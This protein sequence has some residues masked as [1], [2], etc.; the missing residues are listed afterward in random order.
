MSLWDSEN[1]QPPASFIRTLGLPACFVIILNYLFKKWS[2]F[3][4]GLETNRFFLFLLFKN[5]CF[6]GRLGGINNWHNSTLRC[7]SSG[8]GYIPKN[9]F[10]AGNELDI[11]VLLLFRCQPSWLPSV[12]KLAWVS[13]CV[14]VCLCVC[15]AGCFLSAGVLDHPSPPT[16]IFV[17]TSFH[18]W[19][20]TW[21]LCWETLL[22]SSFPV[23]KVSLVFHGFLPAY[24]S[25][26]EL[27]KCKNNF[28][29]CPAHH[30][31]W[32]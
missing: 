1:P 19:Q 14:C 30:S 26:E 5:N 11:H 18:S 16:V 15:K 13:E 9:S 24:T 6:Y 3:F 8:L 12:P 28:S 2:F 10:L 17:L 27:T 22:G 31:A 4:P 21:H 7:V 20:W 25:L 23:S 32:L 29:A